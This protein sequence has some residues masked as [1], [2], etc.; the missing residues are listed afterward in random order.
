MRS[1]L[2]ALLLALVP[3]TA[4]ADRIYNSSSDKGVTHDCAKDPEV[5]INAGE[6]SYTFTGKCTKILLNGS[7]NKLKADS[8]LKLVVSGSKNTVDVEAVD[9]GTLTGNDNVLNYKRGVTGKPK[10]AATGANNK[11]NEVK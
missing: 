9:K 3:A 7:D 10:L 6:G 2:A 1:V 11:L 4:L 8:V 5:I